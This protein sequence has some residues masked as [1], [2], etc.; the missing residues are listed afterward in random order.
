MTGDGETYRSVTI[1]FIGRGSCGNMVHV[2]S[3]HAGKN[4]EG[5]DL[6]SVLNGQMANGWYV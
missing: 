5:N 6:G 1:D 3:R 2:D 4:D